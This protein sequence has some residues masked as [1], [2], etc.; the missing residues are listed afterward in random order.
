MSPHEVVYTHCALLL[1]YTSET[2]QCI[3]KQLLF[4]LVT[5]EASLQLDFITPD[6]NRP[7]IK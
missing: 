5:L 6:K 4:Q 1:E 2:K 7:A 3:I